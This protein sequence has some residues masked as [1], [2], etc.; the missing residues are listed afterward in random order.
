MQL[1][2]HRKYS[3]KM[4]KILRH[5]T[6][7]L[8]EPCTRDGETFS[9]L[10]LYYSFN[11]FVP[12][13]LLACAWQNTA[14]FYWVFSGILGVVAEVPSGLRNIPAASSAGSDLQGMSTCRPGVQE[15][16]T[17]CTSPVPCPAPSVRYAFGSLFLA[18][19]IGLTNPSSLGTVH[20]T[21]KVT[22]VKNKV[23]LVCKTWGGLKMR[24][25]S[26]EDEE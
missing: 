23:M 25:W 11:N 1:C 5:H 16:G 12:F 14:G 22:Q 26:N 3:C 13:T 20:G 4:L 8:W 24:S 7:A 19:G 17:T 21:W 2:T 9:V 6:A 18:H 10:L 15:T